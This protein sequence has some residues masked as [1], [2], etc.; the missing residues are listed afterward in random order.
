MGDAIII[1]RGGKKLPELPNQ[2]AENQILSGFSA[3]G[4]K[5]K[6][7]KGN[8]TTGY[9]SDYEFISM[10][11]QNGKVLVEQ[12]SIIPPLPPPPEGQGETPPPAAKGVYFPNNEIPKDVEVPLSAFGNATV[13]DVAVG[14]SFTSASGLKKVGG[15][16]NITGIDVSIVNPNG[17][18]PAVDIGFADQTN[19][20]N[21]SWQDIAG[22]EH[23][24]IPAGADLSI[25]HSW[26]VIVDLPRTSAESP[27]QV[28]IRYVTQTNPTDGSVM[29]GFLLI[30]LMWPRI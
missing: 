21:L 12:L 13:A 5:G 17:I 20:I 2:A 3:Y 15:A 16:G 18:K 6:A 7:I 8:I 9:K 14:K 1:R 27:N 24:N 28:S 23:L 19:N 10:M 4:A 22:Y 30:E 11:E 29:G 25:L 26:Q